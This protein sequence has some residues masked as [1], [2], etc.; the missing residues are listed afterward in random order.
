MKVLKESS[1]NEEK[2]RNWHSNIDHAD[3]QLAPSDIL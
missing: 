3:V 1:K 2:N